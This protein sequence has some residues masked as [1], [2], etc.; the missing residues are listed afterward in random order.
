M[1]YWSRY[2]TQ[3]WIAQIENRIEDIDYYLKRTLEWCERNGIYDE[4]QIFICN[5]LTCIWVS[6][7]RN[8]QISYKELMELL[9]LEDLETGEDKIYDLGPKF[10]DL[11]HEEMLDLLSKDNYGD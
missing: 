3:L 9:G 10:K 6:H 1:K 2:D 4:R 11:D 7:M 8:E 5:F